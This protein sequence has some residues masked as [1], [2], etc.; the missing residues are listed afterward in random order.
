MVEFIKNMI[1]KARKGG[2]EAGQ[3]K[4]HFYFDPPTW[5]QYKDEVDIRLTKNVPSYAD[6]ICEIE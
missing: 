1:I 5:R 3:A 4:Y 2:V 6:C